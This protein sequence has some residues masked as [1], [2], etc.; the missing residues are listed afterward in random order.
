LGAER[1][2]REAPGELSGRKAGDKNGFVAGGLAADELK[3]GPVE[4]EGFGEEFDEGGIGGGIDGRGCD[5]DF[6]LCA[7]EA[8]NFVAGSAGLQLHRE[9]GAVPFGGGAK[10]GEAHAMF[11]LKMSM[12][13][14]FKKSSAKRRTTM[15]PT[16]GEMS[17]FPNRRKEKGRRIFRAVALR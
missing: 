1:L 3:G 14:G 15:I 17:I 10:A 7:V 5:A 13:S 4:V 12:T 6:E 11:R 2:K 9:E 8:L 16:A